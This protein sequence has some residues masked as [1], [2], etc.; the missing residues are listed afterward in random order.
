MTMNINPLTSSRP[1][2]PALAP[3]ARQKGGMMIESLI[4]LLIL[5]VIGGGIMHTT[6]RMTNAQRDLAVNNIAVNQMRSMLMTRTAGGADLCTGNHNM[7]LPGQTDPVKV[8]IA[9]CDKVDMKIKGITIGGAAQGDQTIKS[10]QP[11]VLETG[12]D[13]ALVRIGGARNAKL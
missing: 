11:L 8:N 13:D 4:G 9:G 5:S 7:N 6:A 12:K 3:L 10:A 2:D 1:T